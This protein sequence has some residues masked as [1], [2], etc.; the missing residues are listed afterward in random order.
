MEMKNVVLLLL[1]GLAQVTTALN[2]CRNYKNLNA[3]DRLETFTGQKPLRCDQ[4]DITPDWYRFT[5]VAGNPQI[6]TTCP[7]TEPGK[8]PWG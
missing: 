3:A 4:R 1:L 2:P 6:P 7:L 8:K 5:G